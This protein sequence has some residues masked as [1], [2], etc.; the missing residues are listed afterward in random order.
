MRKATPLFIFATTICRFLADRRCGHPNELL[1]EVLDFKTERQEEKLD[2]TY[3]PILNKMVAGLSADQQERVVQRFRQIVESI[4]TLFSS[5]KI[6]A[7]SEILGVS[8]DDVDNQLS[9]LHSVLNVP[10]SVDAPVRLLYL[11]FRGFLVDPRKRG[12]NM[13]WMDENNLHSQMVVNCLRIM[14]GCLRID[15]CGLKNPGACRSSIDERVIKSQPPAEVQYAC[16][17]WADH[18]KQADMTV[19]DAGDVYTFLSTH[20]L[21]WVEALYLMGRPLCTSKDY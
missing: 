8:E 21:H 18:I 10:T 17:Y 14:S 11:S 6:S 4:V 2:A 9:M 16:L 3:L 15:L 13:F 7:L 19:E 20:F 5:L 12:V 1:R